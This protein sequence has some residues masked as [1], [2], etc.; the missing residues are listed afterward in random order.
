MAKFCFVFFQNA[1]VNLFSWFDCL[2]YVQRPSG[3]VKGRSNMA[4][5]CARENVLQD[6]GKDTRCVN[7]THSRLGLSSNNHIEEKLSALSLIWL[8]LNLSRMNVT[9]PLY[10]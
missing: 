2:T 1:L 10:P 4:A 5:E 8:N 6:I 7:T 3:E 9:H